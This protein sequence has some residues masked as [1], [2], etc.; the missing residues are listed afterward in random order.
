MKLIGSIRA[1]QD[2]FVLFC[3]FALRGGDLELF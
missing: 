3:R 1:G 2:R